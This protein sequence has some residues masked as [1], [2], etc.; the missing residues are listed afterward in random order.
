MSL[1]DT[2]EYWWDVKGFDRK[3]KRIF[4]HIKGIECG[5]YHVYETK[6]INKIDCHSCMKILY[7]MQDI[8]E[9]LIH[10]NEK[11]KYPYGKCSCGGIFKKRK[12]NL[13]NQQFLGCSN[14]PKC[15]KTKP[16]L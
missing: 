5:H 8:K 7:E 9:Q 13:N 15:K 11:I 2:A 4:T 1:P 12:N 3:Q 6:E 10:E 16:I 14:Y